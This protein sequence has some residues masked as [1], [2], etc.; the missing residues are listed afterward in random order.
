MKKNLI[1]FLLLS[2]AC[3]VRAQEEQVSFSS[4]GGIYETSFQLSLECVYANHHIRYTTNG[5]NPTASSF[6]YEAPLTLGPQLYSHSDIYTIQISPKN[7]IYL[8]DS[9][10]H[11]IVIRAA[12]FDE[13]DSCVSKTVT[14]TYLIRELGF[15]NNGMAVVSICA[16]TLALFDYETGIFVPGINWNPDNPDHSGNYYQKG[17]E[18]ERLANVEFYEPNDNSGINQICGL[19]THGNLSRRHPAK[20][21]KIYAREEYGIKRFNHDFFQDTTLTSFKHLL[22]KPFAVFEPYLGAQDYFCVNLARQLNV[23]SPHCRPVIAYLNGEYWGVYFIQEK[24]DERFLEDHYGVNP[25]LCNIIGNWKGEIENGNNI[26]FQQMMHWFKNADLADYATY[27]QACRMID[28]D[29]F[30]DYYIVEIFVGNW[31]WPGNNMRC[32]QYGDGPWRWI[33]FDGDASLMGGLDFFT[34]AAVYE[35]PTTWL[36]YPE[37]KLLFGKLLQNDQFKEAFSHRAY[38]LCNGLLLY[39]NTSPLLN[40]MIQTLRPKIHDQRQ[41]FGY[42]LSDEQWNQGNNNLISFLSRRTTTFIQAMETFLLHYGTEELSQNTFI[43]FPNP[44]D[45]II[46]I[47]RSEKE[48]QETE[49]NLYNIHGALVYKETLPACTPGDIWSIHPDLSAGIYCI[50]IGNSTQRIVIQ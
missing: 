12:V 11:A 34:L 23:E 6:L 33:F 46:Q 19:R 43:C 24:T 14:N 15:E 7:L 48:S 10:S 4:H 25:D 26:G 27:E 41:R 5:N 28:I 17:R 30:I 38:E 3:L 22:I 50:K 49:L 44:T 40:G 32:W 8:P 13:N 2:A 20:G 1:L 35:P 37:A 18:W 9:V 29:N 47:Q 21:M 36:N 16:D 42:P 45:G 31:D 39:E